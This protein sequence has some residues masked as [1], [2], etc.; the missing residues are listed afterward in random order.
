[1]V[2]LLALALSL[3]VQ[4]SPFPLPAPEEVLTPPAQLLQVSDQELE[5]RALSLLNP[6]SS[7]IVL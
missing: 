3:L 6:Y 7:K 5:Q 4:N 1:M 2:D